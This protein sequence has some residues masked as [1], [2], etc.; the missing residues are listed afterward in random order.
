M[1]S[2]TSC[3]DADPGVGDADHR[4]VAGAADRAG[5]RA[6]G[7]RV[8]QRVVEQ[9]QHQLPELVAVPLDQEPTL[10]LPR[11]HDTAFAGQR[12]HRLDCPVDH[13]GQVEQ[14][15]L[16]PVGRLAAGE[17]QQRVDERRQAVGLATR[18]RR[19]RPCPGCRPGGTRRW[20]GSPPAASAARAR[21]AATKACWR[22]NASCSGASDLP[23]RNQPPTAA[24]TRLPAAGEQQQ[25]QQVSSASFTGLQRAGDLNA[26][27]GAAAVSAR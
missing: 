4:P 27:P 25:H 5:H 19:S 16:R 18:C 1:R 6:A 11:E 13:R 12:L 10:A 3:V 7:R 22:S 15:A 26:N 24:T 20:R 21:R 17:R 2:T 9:D 23:A 14:I 8:A